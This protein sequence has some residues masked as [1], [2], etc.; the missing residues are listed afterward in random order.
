MAIVSLLVERLD[1]GT[2]TK[3]KSKGEALDESVLLNTP[4][5]RGSPGGRDRTPAVKR[6]K[7]GRKYV[8]FLIKK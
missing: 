3:H 5:T 6:R 4:G 1:P 2:I 8:C 7:N